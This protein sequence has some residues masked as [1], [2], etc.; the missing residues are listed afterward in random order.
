MIP[1]LSPRAEELRTR[2]L[3]FMDEQVY[4]AEDELKRHAQSHEGRWEPLPVI[5]RLKAEAK[6]RGLW[7][8][9]LPESEYGAQLSNHEYATL[10]E[11]MG[12]SP[13]LAPEACNCS[14]PDTGNMEVLVRY[15]SEEHKRLWLTPLLEGEIRSCFAMTEPDV[16]SSDASGG[17]AARPIRAA[18]SPS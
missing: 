17:R 4:P 10:C 12:R 16:A 6:K 14:A 1:P 2:L 7:N 11:V 5:A 15:G 3:T 18:R 8:L 13:M 9:F